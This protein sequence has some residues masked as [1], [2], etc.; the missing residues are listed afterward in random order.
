MFIEIKNF[1][2]AE[3]LTFFTEYQ[4]GRAKIV[5]TLVSKGVEYS[6]AIG[7]IDFVFN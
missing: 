1:L 3:R 4:V 5:A 2:K 7:N 6:L